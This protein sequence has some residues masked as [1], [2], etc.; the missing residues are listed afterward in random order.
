MQ[1]GVRIAERTSRPFGKRELWRVSVPEGFGDSGLGVR[2]AI[3]DHAVSE[4]RRSGS[5]GLG[6][7]REERVSCAGI[8]WG[9]Y[10]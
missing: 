6:E 4:E 8:L 1:A 9:M 10:G 5:Q 3:T 2:E 7:G